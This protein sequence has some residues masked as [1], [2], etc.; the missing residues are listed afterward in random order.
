M[1]PLYT[2]LV[3]IN[4]LLLITTAADALT[5]RMISRSLKHRVIVICVL[6]GIASWG[7]YISVVT[8][9]G[10]ESLILLHK[11]AK[12]LE[13]CAA[14]AIGI[15][16]A[17]AYGA[18][19]KRVP[20]VIALSAYVIFQ[21]VALIPG[22]VF[23]VDENNIYHQ[24]KLY[25]V[26]VVSSTVSIIYGI[27]SMVINSQKYYTSFDS[28]MSLSLLILIIGVSIQFICSDVRI[29]FFCV[30]LCNLLFYNRY[31]KMTLQVDALTHLLNR[32]CY[33]TSIRS[34]NGNAVILFFDADRFKQVNDTYGHTVGDICLKNIAS[35][36]L[37]VYGKH[38]SCYRIGGDEFCVILDK[39]LSGLETLN[40]LFLDAVQEMREKDTRM[41]GVSFG[42]A[43]YQPGCSHIQNVLEAADNM[44]YQN[45]PYH[46]KLHKSKN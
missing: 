34:L 12:L 46:S 2:A 5:N 44:L 1:T 35:I 22:W 27:I 32:R 43:H 16:C 14:P 25:W 29:Y 7:E 38:G 42:Y 15:E 45:K 30:S 19:K 28:V 20:A 21:I 40:R 36:L 23:Q 31:C 39:E 33:E 3:L 10:P 41:P 37:S 9:G 17:F 24:E 11:Y 13:V 4:I 26:Y 8:N 18:A 6:I